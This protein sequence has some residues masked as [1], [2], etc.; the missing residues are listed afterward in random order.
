M[1]VKMIH[2]AT[3]WD[4]ELVICFAVELFINFIGCVFLS[5]LDFVVYKMYV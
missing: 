2:S 4:Y 5:Y 1:L 3:H